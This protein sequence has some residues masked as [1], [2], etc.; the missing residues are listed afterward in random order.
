MST[1][2]YINANPLEPHES[3]SLAAGEAFLDAYR[4]ARPQDEI[5]RVDLYRSFV[6]ALDADIL[7]GWNALRGGAAFESLPE[8]ARRKIGRLNEIVDQFLAA[9]KYVFVSPMWNFSYP[10]VL[11]AYLDSICAAG[12]TFRYTA[13]GPVGLVLGRKALH[14]QASGGVYA[15]APASASDFGHHHLRGVL[16]FIGVDDVERLAVEGHNQ[17]PDRRDAIL[18]AAID[19]ARALAR[20]W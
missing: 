8:D 20:Q 6:P 12:K 11:K 3:M 19:R 7:R 5:V 2:L 14:V 16:G 9:D 10:P 17:F 15:E 4:E 18:R 1:L 13:E